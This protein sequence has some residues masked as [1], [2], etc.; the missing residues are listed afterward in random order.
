[1]RSI[2]D[3]LGITLTNNGR[4]LR[5]LIHGA[6]TVMSHI[7]HFYHLA[8]AD[9][10]D[11]SALG[12]PWSSTCNSG[13]A[14]FG[15]TSGLISAMI[16]LTTTTLSGTAVV[17]NYVEALNIRRQA[18]TMGAILSG[19]QPIQNAIV[20]GGATTIFTEA[21][22]TNFRSYLTTVRNFIDQKYIP[23][24]VTVATLTGAMSPYYW[25]ASVNLGLQSPNYA[26]YWQVGTNPGHTLSYG[27]YP[28][29]NEPFSTMAN[30]NMLIA[31]GT[32]TYPLSYTSFDPSDTSTA[33]IREYVNYS[34]YKSY[35]G[36][37]HPSIGKTDPDV[38]LVTNLS[39]QQYSWLKAPRINGV[40]HEVGP[41]ARILATR[42]GP[43]KPNVS[44]V[45][46]LGIDGGSTLLTTLAGAPLGASYN[47]DGLVTY[48]TNAITTGLGGAISFGLT[49]LW[50]PLGR[51]ATRALETKLVADAMD[52]WLTS[53]DLNN[54]TTSSAP[55]Q[56]GSGYTYVPIPKATVS[57][58]GLAEAPRGALGHWIK[59]QSKKIANYQCVVPST[60]NACPRADTDGNTGPAESALTG[61][62]AG[63]PVTE[64]NDAILNIARM[65]HPYDF[66]IA[67]AVHVVNAQGKEIAKFAMDESGKVTKL[68]LDS[69]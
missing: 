3:A 40:A 50:S 38:S 69:E 15:S 43:Y 8:A 57:G 47:I 60:W 7:T 19:R 11:I 35:D 48:A 67:C 64:V 49:N 20:P 41:L 18:H 65:L 23:D 59:I 9:F 32:V 36:P 39:A 5:N 34:Y 16:P 25:A 21:D 30:T 22:R 1:V 26:I 46:G 12:S 28:G 13:G 53:L 31:R 37:L 45:N 54:A 61:V 68:P 51:H 42:L 56:T 10:V 55:T 58:M 24:V 33:G 44:Q 52:S 27:E 63:N 14:A 17:R 29:F 62:P 4:L 2:D 66:C 6:D